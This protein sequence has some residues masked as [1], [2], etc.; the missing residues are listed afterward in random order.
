MSLCKFKKRC[1]SQS[2]DNVSVFV[3]LDINLA[4]QNVIARILFQML[5]EQSPCCLR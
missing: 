2:P 5:V 1:A 3:S 4:N